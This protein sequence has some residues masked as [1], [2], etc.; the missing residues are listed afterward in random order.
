[1]P[2]LKEHMGDVTVAIICP[3]TYLVKCRACDW[4][5]MSADLDEL[6]VWFS[7]HRAE[8]YRK[9]KPYAE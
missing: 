5:K 4:S 2:D 7:E 9:E 3:K 6:R 8:E 1:M